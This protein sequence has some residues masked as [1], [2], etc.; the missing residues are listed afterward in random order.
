MKNSLFY[1]LFYILLALWGGSGCLIQERAQCSYPVIKIQQ[2]ANGSFKGKI[3]TICGNWL[4]IRTF[5]RLSDSYSEKIVYKGK[6]KHEALLKIDSIVSSPRFKSLDHI[7]STS[8][9]GG[10]FNHKITVERNEGV[11]EVY[12]TDVKIE[13]IDR[14][15]D[16]I[17][18]STNSKHKIQTYYLR[19][20]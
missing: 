20:E 2:R 8:A 17:N 11:Q 7:Y 4:F 14:L 3:Y 18:S 10:F 13:E 6:L 15:F 16:V 12:I 5:K 1:F 9:L 19:N